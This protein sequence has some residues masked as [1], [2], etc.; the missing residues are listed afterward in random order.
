MG[1]HLLTAMILAR[2]G[3]LPF[4]QA[5]SGT[6]L[7]CGPADCLKGSPP[8]LLAIM[9]MWKERYELKEA[10]RQERGFI[11]NTMFQ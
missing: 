10:G 8:L 2:S 5:S 6:S 7:I 9:L 11:S 1:R 4:S 3:R